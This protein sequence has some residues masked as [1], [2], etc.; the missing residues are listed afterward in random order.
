[1][2]LLLLLL[3]FCV[4]TVFVTV[5]KGR[6]TADGPDESGMDIL[7]MITG[8]TAVVIGIIS[9]RCGTIVALLAAIAGM[10]LTLLLLSSLLMF[11]L[12]AIVIRRIGAVICCGCGRRDAGTVDM[13]LETVVVLLVRFE[14]SGQFCCK[15]FAARSRKS[16]VS[17]HSLC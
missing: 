12:G 15:R 6:R 1:M 10:L 7:L 16:A 3:P 14:E 11:A 2:V 4:S 17:Q 9:G 8:R 5:D 13:A